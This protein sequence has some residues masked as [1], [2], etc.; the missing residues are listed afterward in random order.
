MRTPTSATTGDTTIESSMADTPH[1]FKDNELG[2]LSVN[3]LAEW[4]DSTMEPN[5]SDD[6]IHPETKSDISE[7]ELSINSPK[8]DKIDEDEIVTTPLVAPTPV[9]SCM[10]NKFNPIQEEA[11]PCASEFLE[12]EEEV[13]ARDAYTETSILTVANEAQTSI[14]G[15]IKPIGRGLMDIEDIRHKPEIFTSFT[16]FETYDKF[17]FILETLTP[18]AYNLNY[19]WYKCS[20]VSVPNQL[21]MTL[22]K[23]RKHMSNIDL[24]YLF[25]VSD[26][27]V[28]NIICTWLNLMYFQWGE[29]PIWA[30]SDLVD[31][32]SP[33]E[34]NDEFPRTRVIVDGM[35]TPMVKAKNPETQQMTWSSYKN[36]N[37]LKSLP[38]CT[39]GGL[40]NYIP[41]AYGASASDRQ[42]CERTTLMTGC[43]P[44]DQVMSDKGFPTQDLFAPYDV[45]VNIPTK[46]KRTTQFDPSD[47][48]KDR[49]IASK[50]VIIERVIGMAK[51]YKIL[52][53]RLDEN[54]ALMGTQIIFA[55]FMLG[56]FRNCLVT[57]N[58]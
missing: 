19:R 5:D 38:G 26:T 42:L 17:K 7:S 43:D 33:T 44:K 14:T 28:S 54:E 34:F 49:K 39:P 40:T 23:L 16:G 12:I 51:S 37:G 32:F 41:P 27:T 36:C 53:G 1:N 50:R 13:Q 21:L 55:C 4:D 56:N 11:I 15:H 58:R 3:S 22:I 9:P 45:G 25:A 35:E 10:D 31:F 30:S 18:A 24:S 48:S 8:N 2:D 20:N 57:E 6:S 47:L 52:E 46:L 29:L